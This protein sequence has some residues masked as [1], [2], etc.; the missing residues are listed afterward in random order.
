MINVFA[1]LLV[2]VRLDK[3]GQAKTAWK[4]RGMGRSA[5]CKFGA[6]KSGQCVA[7]H[8]VDRTV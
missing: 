2:L 4:Q 6:T 3:L 8:V 1:A 5:S 7:N